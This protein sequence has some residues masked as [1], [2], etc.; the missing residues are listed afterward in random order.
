METEIQRAIRQALKEDRIAQ[1]I[2]TNLLVSKDQVSKAFIIVK[3]PAVICGLEIVAAIFRKLD[4]EVQLHFLCQEGD[5]VKEN[6]RVVMI[7]GKTRAI[8]SCERVALNFLAYLSG[9]ATETRKFIKRVSPYKVKI[10]DT[11]K[12]IPGLRALVKMAV[13]CGGGVNHRFNLKEMV[14]IKDN[15]Q[16]AYPKDKTI[17]DAIRQVRKKTKKLIVVEV[18]TLSQFK[19]ALAS[20]PDIILLDNMTTRQ[21]RKAVK[22][23]N[24]DPKRCLLEASGGINLRNIRSVARTG[25]DRISVGALT[26]SPKAIDFSMEFIG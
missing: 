19:E 4:P 18:D 12:T 22:L 7:K 3:E 11:R 16:V 15:H 25:V 26:H 6:S 21:I 9:I 14:M 24:A 1:D 8:L 17:Q 23:N 10:M 13:R 20:R 2:T 5:S